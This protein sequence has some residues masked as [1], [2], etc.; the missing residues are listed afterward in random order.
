MDKPTAS[1]RSLQDSLGEIGRSGVRRSMGW[2]VSWWHVVRVGALILVLALSPSTYSRANRAALARHIVVG[3]AP[4]LPWFA[5][6]AALISVVLIRIVIVTAQSYGLSQYAL[7]MMVRVLVLELI[8]LAAALFVALRNTVPSGAELVRMHARGEFEA[9]QGSGTDALRHEL[10]PR[11]IAG[12]FAVLMLAAVSCLIA[13]VLAYLA[14][15]G[16]TLAG[17]PGFTHTLGHI[18][19][20]AVTLIFALKT[21]FFSFAVALIPVAA[22]LRSAAPQRASPELDSLVRL[23]AAILLIEADSLM[24][25]YY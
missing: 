24:G 9:L 19:N 2:S 12:V 18:F 6:L 4:M 17:L 25:N 20:P 13:M 21:L 14:V 11:V 16:F 5:M 10:L 15:Y 23:L 22:F 7:E 3:T 8:P 1:L